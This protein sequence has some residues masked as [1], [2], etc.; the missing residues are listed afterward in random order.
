MVALTQKSKKDEAARLNTDYIESTPMPKLWS[1]AWIF[2]GKA[3]GSR[4]HQPLGKDELHNQ[5]VRCR[6]CMLLLQ[7]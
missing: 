3:Q 6:T 5:A 4:L 2:Y 7:H 1:M